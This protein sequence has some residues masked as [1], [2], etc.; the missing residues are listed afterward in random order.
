[1]ERDPIFITD[2]MHSE[3]YELEYQLAMWEISRPY[4]FYTYVYLYNLVEG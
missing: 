3:T 2:Q 4:S 1:M